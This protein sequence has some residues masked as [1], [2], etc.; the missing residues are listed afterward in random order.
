[1]VRG[2][3]KYDYP[4]EKTCPA[5]R[6]TWEATTSKE[7]E[8]KEACSPECSGALRSWTQRGTSKERESKPP[9]ERDGTVQVECA[10]CGDDHWIYRSR[11]KIKERHF[12][13][14][15]CYDEWKGS[16]PDRLNHLREIAPKGERSEEYLQDLSESMKGENNPAWKGGVTE[17]KRKGN[18]KRE[19]LVRCP[20]EYS[21]MARANGYV[22]VH[23]LKVAKEL[24][25]PLTSTEVVHH[26]DHDNHNNDLENLELWPNNR[27]HKLAEGNREEYLSERLWP[28]PPE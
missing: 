18:Y 8:E 1:M 14:Q 9:E 7:V 28:E 16:N 22:P 6:L 15:A 20:D 11:E 3:A 23:R 12:C 2:R 24:G 5:C 27:L 26:K 17:K 21:E 10:N 25:R 19:K 4:V 13:K